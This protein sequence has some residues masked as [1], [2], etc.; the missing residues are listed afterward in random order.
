MR[1]YLLTM[2]LVNYNDL[3]EWYKS[4]EHIKT[5]YRPINTINNVNDVIKSVFSIHNETFNIWS[6]FLG[7]IIFIAFMITTIYEN[8]HIY[9]K[10]ILAGYCACVLFCFLCS[11]IY[12][13]FMC[14]S[15]KLHM[16][17]LTID[18]QGTVIHIFGVAVI[19][20][21]NSFQNNMIV[22]Y[23]YIFSMF[24]VSIIISV[25]IRDDNWDAPH[26]KLFRFIIFSIN[27]LCLF[28][29][30]VHSYVIGTIIN[31]ILI[32]F[33]L[34]ILINGI[35]GVCYGFKFPE[36]KYSNTTLDY[37]GNSHNI[38]HITVL[39]GALNHYFGM[40]YSMLIIEHKL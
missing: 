27:T 25:M 28:V 26:R 19:T 18:Y 36:I 31:L 35:G 3:P 16:D 13:I 11:T 22:A 2:K 9:N 32:T 17:C 33:I 39:L 34:T 12:H 23:S 1:I 7:C 15:H 24:I 40:Y 5:G 37:I 6:H 38:M 29:P 20:I 30:I 10:I 21:H 4:N 14:H 8:L